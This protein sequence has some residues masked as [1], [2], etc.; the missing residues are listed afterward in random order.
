MAQKL[1][2]ILKSSS[3]KG[4]APLI[5]IAVITIS[6]IIGGSAALGWLGKYGTQVLDAIIVAFFILLQSVGTI[7]LSTAGII[8][9]WV[10]SPDFINISFTNNPFVTAGWGIVRD[11]ANMFFIIVLMV[12]GLATALRRK[13]YEA[14][15]TLPLLII[16][17]LLINFT[18][19]ICGFI[20]DASN[21]AMNFF[22]SEVGT[23][24][25]SA[26]EKLG[27][28]WDKYGEMIEQGVKPATVAGYGLTMSIF[29][30]VTAFVYLIFALLFLVRY[31][32][33][34][35]LVILSPIA[36]FCY[37]LPA[38]RSAW[39]MW[40]NQ[41]IQWCIVGVIGGFFLYMAELMNSQFA[42]LSI[43][44]PGGLEGESLNAITSFFPFLV[45][46]IFLIIGLFITLSSSATGASFAMSGAAKGSKWVGAKAFKAAKG[47]KTGQK[48]EKWTRE[49][50]EKIPVT[51]RP[52]QYRMEKEKQRE[53][54]KKDIEKYTPE[55]RTKIRKRRTTPFQEKIALQQVALE[56]GEISDN[57][58]RR[59]VLEL[60]RAGVNL[61]DTME[62]RPDLAGVEGIRDDR[63]TESQAIQEQVEGI[64]RLKFRQEAKPQALKNKNVLAAMSK[65]QME[66]IKIKG[67][68]E[69][70]KSLQENAIKNQGEMRGE[71]QR[72]QREAAQAAALAA[73]GVR[74]KAA[75]A[76]EKAQR[77]E[78]INKNLDTII[79][80]PNFA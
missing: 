43:T 10:I 38:T 79:H 30:F 69:Q 78:R 62:K 9:S 60:K 34:W 39:S 73:R 74:E 27:Q 50:M 26:V 46:I 36:F 49:K 35:T 54:I 41:F 40:W 66:E 65:E 44:A 51:G 29:T 68:M 24:L 37:I 47:T 61:K 7:F 16:I 17:A 25:G 8:L 32:A 1:K 70:R 71:T 21:I 77:A 18:P 42:D 57:E 48:M 63:L 55:E 4:V 52:G 53:E 33:L 6:S 45:P 15:K 72:L 80:D 58:E 64:S 56:K 59:T 28:S 19:V 2:K 67:T 31:I 22:L 75:E 11:F 12:I 23:G 13:E 76:R 3:E 5:I 14:K 20:I